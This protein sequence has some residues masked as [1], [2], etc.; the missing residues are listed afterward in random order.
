[1]HLVNFYPAAILTVPLSS[2]NGNG[3]RRITGSKDQ[4]KVPQ[5]HP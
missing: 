1:M 5:L 4:D 3:S 2:D